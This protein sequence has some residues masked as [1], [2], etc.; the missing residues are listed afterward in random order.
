VRARLGITAARL[1]LDVMVTGPESI[2]P[3]PRAQIP[4]SDDRVQVPAVP[5]AGNTMEQICQI[6]CGGG[7]SPA[8]S[9][10]SVLWHYVPVASSGKKAMKDLN[11]ILMLCVA[12]MASV[13]YN[14]TSVDE[15]CTN[16][17]SSRFWP[18]RSSICVCR[19]AVQ[20]RP[21]DVKIFGRFMTHDQ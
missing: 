2:G 14:A 9:C 12:S 19:H 10:I 13:S 4:H 17:S 3:P 16:S 1:F 11:R 15:T 18:G 8:D 21:I 5:A 20:S 7:S 6:L